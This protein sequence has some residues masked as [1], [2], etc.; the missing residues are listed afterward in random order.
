[1][2]PGEDLQWPGHCCPFCLMTPSNSTQIS[3][4]HSQV[5]RTCPHLH[6]YGPQVLHRPQ[7]CLIIIIIFFLQISKG[8]QQQLMA[9]TSQT[10]GSAS[11][12][13][14]SAGFTLALGMHAC[15]S[16]ILSFLASGTVLH[17]FDFCKSWMKKIGLAWVQGVS[18]TLRH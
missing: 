9:V 17:F 15:H 18:L 1:M 16:N 12:W 13:Q 5:L 10:C 8:V 11:S 6:R 4:T 14:L 2:S 3:T 7:S